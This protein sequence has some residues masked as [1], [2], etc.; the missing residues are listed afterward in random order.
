M[1]SMG[2]LRVL[3]A[4]DILFCLLLL[5]LYYI[6]TDTSFSS[7]LKSPQFTTDYMIMIYLCNIDLLQYD[8]GYKRILS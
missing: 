1:L 7:K 2:L 5:Q 8:H 4:L 3:Y 6:I